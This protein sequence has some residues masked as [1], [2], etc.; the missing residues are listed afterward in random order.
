MN[1]NTQK[2]KPYIMLLLI[3]QSNLK[4]I[5]VKYTKHLHSLNKTGI[6]NKYDL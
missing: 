3:L 4:Q 1:L 6:Y 2:D 5:N